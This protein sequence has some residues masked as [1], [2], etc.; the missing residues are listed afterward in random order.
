MDK[1]SL[2]GI[3]YLGYV[4]AE[5]IDEDIMYMYICGIRVAL[6]NLDIT[7]IKFFGNPTCDAASSY[8]KNGRVELATLKFD[9][10]KDLPLHKHLAFVIRDSNGQGYIIGQHEKPRPAVKV[11]HNTGSPNGEAAVLSY[12]VTLYGKK[13]L[14]PCTF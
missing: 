1:Q 14:I 7:E 8:N 11:T 9:T 5:S 13:A 6:N 10:L 4:E 3:T 12:E 2:P